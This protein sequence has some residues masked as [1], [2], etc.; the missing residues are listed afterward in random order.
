MRREVQARI[1]DPFLARTD[2][3]WMGFGRRGRLNNWSPWCSS[4][5]LSAILLLEEDRGRRAQGVMKVMGI[6]DRFLAGYFPD[7]GCDEG[8]SYWTVAGGSLFDCLELL[9]KRVSGQDRRLR[10]AAGQRDRPL[11]LPGPYQRRLLPQLCRLPGEGAPPGGPGLPLWP[12][13]R[14]RED[15]R[16]GL[17][18]LPSGSKPGIGGRRPAARLAECVLLPGDRGSGEAAPCP[19]RVAGW[20]PGDGGKRAGGDPTAGCTWQ[21][22]AATTTRATT[23]MMWDSSWSTRTGSRC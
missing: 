2:F 22:R 11:Y 19:R 16:P 15:G 5:C 10:G 18:G 1:L 17:M 21:R 4:T 23:T 8:P 6:L 3:W 12:A 14:G 20:D 13:Y 9:H 7:G